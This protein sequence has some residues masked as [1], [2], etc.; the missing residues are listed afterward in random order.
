MSLFEEPYCDVPSCNGVHERRDDG[1][2]HTI[3][4]KE[5]SHAP[6]MSLFEIGPFTLP[7]GRTTHFKIECDVLTDA[8]WAALA[9]LAVELLPP[10]GRVEGVPQGG[11]PFARALEKYITPNHSRLLIADDVWVSGL[12][13]NRHR[14]GRVAVGVVAFTRNPVAKWVK[15]LMSLNAEAEEATYQLNQPPRIIV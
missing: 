7:S 2:Y 4:T 14:A 1:E 13:M 15:S 10:F 12:S 5:S 3:L 9:R 11:I 8:D 6:G